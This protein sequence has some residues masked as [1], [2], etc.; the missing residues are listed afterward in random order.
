MSL[1][2]Q[3]F[4]VRRQGVCVRGK[5]DVKGTKDLHFFL[6]AGTKYGERWQWL[7]CT[8][9]ARKGRCHGAAGV[10]YGRIQRHLLI[11]DDYSSKR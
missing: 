4:F 1:W 7:A 8:R 2:S 11:G 6:R 3:V 9:K 5:L 10:C